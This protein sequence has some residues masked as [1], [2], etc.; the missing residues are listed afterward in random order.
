MCRE[1]RESTRQKAHT[2]ND[3]T[4]V[5]A[6]NLRLSAKKPIIQEGTGALVSNKAPTG[7]HSN[8]STVQRRKNKNFI[9]TQDRSYMTGRNEN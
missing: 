4:T 8:S 7:R 9:I 6:K 1:I 5:E 2:R 3:F